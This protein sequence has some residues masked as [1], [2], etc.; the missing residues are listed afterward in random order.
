MGSKPLLLPDLA[1]L[2]PFNHEEADSRMLLH[3]YHAAQHGH[4]KI[5]QIVDT[6]VVVLAVSMAQRLQPEDELW[7]AFGTGKGFRYLAA[8]EVSAG[9]GPEKA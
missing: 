9:L 6:D 7:V 3:T 5:V 4:Q 2:T 8:H 1:S